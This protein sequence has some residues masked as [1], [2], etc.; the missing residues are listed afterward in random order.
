MIDGLISH[1]LRERWSQRGLVTAKNPIGRSEMQGMAGVSVER[2]HEIGAAFNR[3][4][5]DFIVASF[6][7]DGV[8]R[9]AMGPDG[10]GNTYKGKKEIRAFFEKLFASTKDI[11]WNPTAE[12][13]S[14]NRGIAEWHRTATT[15]SGEKQDWLG[16]DIFTFR[17]NMIVLKD[18][19]FKIKE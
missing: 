1:G 19:F 12:Y 9:N 13:V 10:T 8:F 15:A 18:T 6:A 7:E 5:V 17:D 4:D 2:V 16:C 3:H 14:G 11:Q